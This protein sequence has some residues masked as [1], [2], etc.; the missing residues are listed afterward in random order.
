[1]VYKKQRDVVIANYRGYQTMDSR[2]HPDVVRGQKANDLI[3]NIKYKADYEDSKEI[4]CF[5]YTL[6]D[7]YDKIQDMQKLKSKFY[8]EDHEN[9]KFKNNFNVSLTTIYEHS[10][11]V[12]SVYSDIT[13]KEAYEKSKGH[14]LGTDETPEMT[15][16][17]DLYPIQSQNAY[18]GEAKAA[19]TRNHV[20]AD[21][22]QIAHALDMSMQASDL[23]YKSEYKEETLGKS[24][25][26]PAI[27]YPEH[28]RLKRIKDLTNKVGKLFIFF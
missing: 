20:D 18:T 15:R 23:Y 12:A 3:S 24:V 2:V 11:D 28:E 22:Q 1:M 10:K 8:Q 5:P 25:N 27:A 13:Y 26:D 4:L 7:Q 17:R 21:G 6:T 14:N 9:T 16:A 19:M